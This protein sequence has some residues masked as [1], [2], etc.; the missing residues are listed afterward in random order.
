M[1]EANALLRA[2]VETPDDDGV[3]LVHADWLEDHGQPER[4]EFIR[5]QVELEPHRF[6]IDRPRVRQ[7]LTREEELR[8]LHED[9]WLG[10][11]VAA[12]RAGTATSEPALYGPYFRRGVPEVVALSLY[13]LPEY[14]EELLA[15]HPTIREL[16]VL[17]VQ[18]CGD[19]LACCDLPDR[20]TTLEVGDWLLEGDTRALLASP[21]FRRLQ[22]VRV[23]YGEGQPWRP[24][25]EEWPPGMR[26]EVVELGG[27]SVGRPGQVSGELDELAGRFA[28]AGRVLV[29]VRPAQERFPL[30]P[31]QGQNL[32]P[33]RLPDGRQLLFAHGRDST[34]PVV[35]AYFDDDGNLVESREAD[36]PGCCRYYQDYPGWLAKEL[37]DSPCL[38]WM[39]EFRTH[40]GLGIQLLPEPPGNFFL[41]PAELWRWLYQGQY[42]ITWC[43]TP[44][45][46]RRSGEITDT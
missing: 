15:A 28:E 27:A 31:D 2:I 8:R 3:R 39:R 21:R 10:P 1:T 13:Q 33:G 44:W 35:F 40:R 24:R 26:L 6:D 18:G 20:I 17:D 19:G 45:A 38:I 41:G 32:H 16:A 11:A 29:P 43:N 34:E 5:V 22:T 42:V 25:P 4:A 7:L 30:L 37:G 23:W 36:D 46:S 14:G 9:D 12:M